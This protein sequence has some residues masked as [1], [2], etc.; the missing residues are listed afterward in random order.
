MAVL[1]KF[2][3]SPNERLRYSIDYDNWLD[4]TE[5]LSTATF[6]VTPVTVPPLAVDGSLIVEDGKK[7][8]F[9]MSGGVDRQDYKVEVFAATSDSQIREDVITFKVRDP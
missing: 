1:S 8:V 9:Y 4:T 6:T 2:E 5:V 7:L 3:Q